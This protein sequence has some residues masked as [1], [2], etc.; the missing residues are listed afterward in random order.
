MTSLNDRPFWSLHTHSKFSVNDALPS[1]S[2]RGEGRRA[3]L[4]SPWLDRPRQPQRQHRLYSAC[5]KFGIEPLPGIELY[6]VPDTEY[7]SSQDNVHLTIAAYTEHRLPQPGQAGQPVRA[8]VLVQAADRPRRL[9][10]DGR[11]RVPRGPGGGHRL[12]SSGCCRRSAWQPRGARPRSRC[13]RPWPAG[14]RKVY[15]ELQNH[16]IDLRD[17]DGPTSPTTRCSRACGTSRQQRRAA[18]HGHP[19]QPLHQPRG[20]AP[21]RRRSSGWCPGARTRTTR[22]SPATATT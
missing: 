3:G 11:G 18:G 9:R 14:S 13:R 8:A 7:A 19:G 17:E 1:P 6:V 2:M 15:V 16:G 21:A 4:P 12:P 10:R 22:S 20:Q 5:R